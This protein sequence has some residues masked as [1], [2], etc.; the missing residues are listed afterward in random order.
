MI[1]FIEKNRRLLVQYCMVLRIL[2]WLLV[3]YGGIYVA[4][5]IITSMIEDS[6]KGIL[7]FFV[8]QLFF[9]IGF[10]LLLLGFGQLVRYLCDTDSEKGL[11][12]LYGERIFYLFAIIVILRMV[13]SILGMMIGLFSGNIPFLS[14][15]SLTFLITLLYSSAKI[16]ILVGLGQFLK[17]FIAAIEQS[18]ETAG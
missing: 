16:F 7:G 14:V 18:K 13:F 1:E 15:F 5:L 12:L 10:G 3:G 2:G 6:S 17:H 8:M 4:W 11:L 9:S